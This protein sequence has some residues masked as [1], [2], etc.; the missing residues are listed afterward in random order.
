M[1]SST[2]EPATLLE[3]AQSFLSE[4]KRAVLLGTA[5]ALAVGGVA[6]YAATSSRPRSELDDAE[7]GPKKDKKKGGKGKK[8]KTVKDTEGPILEERERPKPN[9]EDADALP[10]TPLTA[11]QIASMSTEERARLAATFKEKGNSA[12]KE[13]RYAQAAVLYTRAIEVTP[14]PEPVFYSNRA[15]C[16][17]NMQPP[18]HALVVEDCDEAL[19]LDSNYVKA[20]NRRAIA[21]EGLDR[22]EEALRDF[23]AATILDKFSNQ[24]TAQAVERVL[25]KLAS[26]KAAEII[27]TREPRLPSFTFI[28]AYFAAFRPRAHPTMPE[29]PST[30]DQ[31]LLL[32]LQALDAADYA[33]AVTFAGEAIDQGISWDEGRAE[34]LNLRGTFKYVIHLPSRANC[35]LSS[36]HLGS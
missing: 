22:F 21:L 29:N 10:D 18:Q 4:N 5:A 15:A 24:G 36:L 2:P 25:Q 27:A 34:A 30:G 20:L 8:K 32:A 16:Y 17:V 31:T 35:F 26:K 11:E 12:Y 3:R 33:H 7:K 1:A 6:Y 28:Q 9:V 13:R 14:K 23:T 19:K